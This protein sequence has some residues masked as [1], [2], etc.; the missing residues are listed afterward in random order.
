MRQDD[1]RR[2]SYGYFVRPKSETATGSARVEPVL[3][4]VVAAPTGPIL[5]DTGLGADPETEAH[6]RPQRRDV[7]DAVAE[8]GIDVTAVSRV[9]NCHLHFD[10]CGGNDR[11]PGRPVLVQRTE[12]QNARQSDYTVPSAI[13]FDG[14]IYEEI[15]GDAEIAPGI[16]I[17]PTP[18]H[19]TGHQSLVVRCDD[20]TVV[21]AGQ[22]TDFAG[23]LGTHVLGH[24]ALGRVTAADLAPIPPWVERLLA[25]DPRRIVFAH[26]LSVLEP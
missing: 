21:C 23:E 20:G 22:A 14:A 10:H 13:E 5:F 24:R 6:Y 18:G 2:L 17:V 3:G 25:F 19:T 1:V 11:F 8:A 26:D 9:V 12:L 7:A 16:W 4:Y 15:E